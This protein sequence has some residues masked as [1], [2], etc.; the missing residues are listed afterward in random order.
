MPLG[1]QEG[2]KRSGQYGYRGVYNQFLPAEAASVKFGEGPV[3]TQAQYRR[4]LQN[5]G[6]EGSNTPLQFAGTLKQP[7][8]AALSFFEAEWT[9]ADTARREQIIG[10]LGL[11]KTKYETI[12]NRGGLRELYPF[13]AER[14]KQNIGSYAK[15]V[16][17]APFAVHKE[18]EAYYKATEVPG[19][20]QPIARR[21]RSFY[22]SAEC[23]L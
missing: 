2:G 23:R 8:G 17:T 16:T 20:R 6:V 9:Q 13:I 22:D 15:M 21:S 11:D 10:E 7:A 5:W 12:A 14:F 19:S 18:N 3:K 1:R 4:G